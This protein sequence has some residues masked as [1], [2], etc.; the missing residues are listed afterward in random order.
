M[1]WNLLYQQKIDKGS[2]KGMHR[3]PPPPDRKRVKSRVRKPTEAAEERNCVEIVYLRIF[4]LGAD[5]R[6]IIFKKR[7]NSEKIESRFF[8]NL[9]SGPE[10]NIVDG[11]AGARESRIICKWKYRWILNGPG[12]QTNENIQ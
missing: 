5:A 7:F 11:E 4:T 12:V 3:S 2:P 10:K 6:L 9:Y 8:F 1:E